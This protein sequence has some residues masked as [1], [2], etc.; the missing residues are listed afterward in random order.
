MGGSGLSPKGRKLNNFEQTTASDLITILTGPDGCRGDLV[1]ATLDALPDAV[2]VFDSTQ[3]V[4][5]ANSAA[6]RSLNEHDMAADR[7]FD[8]VMVFDSVTQEILSPEQTSGGARAR[9]RIGRSRGLRRAAHPPQCLFL[10]RMQRAAGRQRRS[11]RRSLRLPRHQHPQESRTGA[12]VGR[13]ASRLYIQ[14]RT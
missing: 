6:V 2:L 7:P 10:A 12:R 4:L 1:R 8:S 11:S 3:R 14:R 5:F 9:G 13:A